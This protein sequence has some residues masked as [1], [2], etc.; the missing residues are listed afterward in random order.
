MT[1]INQHSIDRHFH[2]SQV[3]YSASTRAISLMGSFISLNEADRAYPLSF[4]TRL[5]INKTQL[6]NP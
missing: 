1:L 6:R 3:I 5:L 2:H 4:D